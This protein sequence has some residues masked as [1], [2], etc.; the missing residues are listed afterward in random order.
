MA[1]SYFTFPISEHIEE[2]PD[3]FLVAR[4]AV[5]ARSGWFEYTCAELGADKLKELGFDAGPEEM[6]K[7]YRPAEEMFHPDTLGSM[8]GKPLT[9]NHPEGG[10]F[11]GPENSRDLAFGHIQ[12]VRK[13]DK[14]LPSGDYAVLAD[15]H[16]QADPLIS[17]I[18]NKVKRELSIGFNYRLVRN[19]DRLEMHDIIVNHCAVVP[20]GRAG[21]E[22]RIVDNEPKFVQKGV[23]LGSKGKNSSKGRGK[24]MDWK[25]VFGFGLKAADAEPEELTDAAMEMARR[26]RDD[27]DDREEAEDLEVPKYRWK[28]GSK[29]RGKAKASRK[30]A[31][32]KKARARDAECDY[33]EALDRCLQGTADDVDIDE[34]VRLLEQYFEEEAEEPEHEEDAHAHYDSEHEEKYDAEDED[35]DEEEQEEDGEEEFEQEAKQEPKLELDS[36]RRLIRPSRDEE[37]HEPEHEEDGEEHE[38]GEK[39]RDR[40]IRMTHDRSY[41]RDGAIEVLKALRPV[42]ART[43]DRNVRRAYDSIVRELARS[44]RPYAGGYREFS[45]RARAHDGAPKARTEAEI[46]REIDE[47]FAKARAEGRK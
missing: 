46:S 4:D 19:G 24:P 11:V 13:S 39:S 35:E 42:A 41:A 37:H 25:R 27:E 40:Q 38:E 30:L 1:N 21:R 29:A 18:R 9:D 6:I 33:H 5:V 43:R 28:K 10:E 31:R 20:R 23:A 22:A 47:I 8:E 34:L 26:V 14:P 15:I 12:N 17:E 36:L 44:S 16:V 2:T 3:G 45:E 7:V 32:L